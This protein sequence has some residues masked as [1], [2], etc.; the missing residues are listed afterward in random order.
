MTC[1]KQ[2]QYLAMYSSGDA[3]IPRAGRRFQ[4]DTP[5]RRLLRSLMN[6]RPDALEARFLEIQDALQLLLPLSQLH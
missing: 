1:W 4:I 6:V 2:I 5:Q 3:P